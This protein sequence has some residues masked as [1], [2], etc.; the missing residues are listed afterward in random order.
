MAPEQIMRTQEPDR[1]TDIYGLGAV[2]YYMLTGHP[3]FYADSPIEVMMAHVR[4][5]VKPPSELRPEIPADLER[6]VIRCL[7]KDPHN[8]YQDTQSLAL[9]LERCADAANWS[10]SHAALWWQEHQGPQPEKPHPQP[11]E[12]TRSPAAETLLVTHDQRAAAD[13]FM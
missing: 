12:Q 7:A 3:P 11:A 9:D 10:P 6:V 4:D 8:R 5:T 13:G 2:A 1:R